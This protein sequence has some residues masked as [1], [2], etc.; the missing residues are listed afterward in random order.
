MLNNIAANL[1]KQWVWLVI[2]VL[3]VVLILVIYKDTVKAEYIMATTPENK[4]KSFLNDATKGRNVRNNNPG[5]V[6]DSREKWRGQIDAKDDKDS[7]FK[8][9]KTWHLGCRAMVKLVRNYIS[10]LGRNTIRKI[11]AA[12]APDGHGTN[13][14]ATYRQILRKYTGKGDDDILTADKEMLWKL[15]QG[16]FYMESEIQDRNLYTRADFETAYNL[17]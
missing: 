17:I 10:V 7:N 16:I 9:F 1:K 6:W 3:I 8:Q 4:Q 13:H 2:A 12:Y 15:T 5:N 14:E 11:V